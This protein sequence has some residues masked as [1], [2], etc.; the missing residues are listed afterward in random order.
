MSKKSI[1]NIKTIFAFAILL[2]FGFMT[3]CK[4][5]VAEDSGNKPS[6]NKIT[7]FGFKKTDN[8]V[9]TEDV[10][11]VIDAADK[12]GNLIAVKFPVGTQID[13]LKNLKPYFSV[14]DGVKLY[15]GD[16]VLTSGTTRV[17]FSDLYNGVKIKA[18]SEDGSSVSFTCNSEIAFPPASAGD[19]DKF[20]GSYYGT[21]PG[22]GDVVIVI[23]KGK[24][25]LY[26]K[27]M[28][29]DY[30]NVEWIKMPGDNIAC[31]TYKKGKA[32]V[33]NFMG[34]RYDFTP[35]TTDSHGKTYPASLSTMIMNTPVTATK[36]ADFTWTEGKGL[37][38][39]EH[40]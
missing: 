14:A 8:P 19:I 26:S 22:R 30:V 6:E 25:T 11:A 16:T 39:A 24:V 21:I 36:G 9:F 13:S 38:P 15:V 29:M 20:F 5:D 1:K 4:N 18:Q 28:S 35:V 2:V 31:R 7:E 23:E 3:G 37:K 40:L 27:I 32:Q 17:D 12:I 10:K 34:Q 33:K